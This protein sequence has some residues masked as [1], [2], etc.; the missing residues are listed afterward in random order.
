[1]D[2]F[3]FVCIVIGILLIL[4]AFPAIGGFIWMQ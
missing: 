1:M 3:M 4:F 2:R